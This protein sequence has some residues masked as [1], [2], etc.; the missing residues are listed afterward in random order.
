MCE[1]LISFLNASSGF[2]RVIGLFLALFFVPSF[3]FC[4][5]RSLLRPAIL[6]QD[7][8]LDQSVPGTERS[9]P[10]R[11]SRTLIRPGFSPDPPS[12][13]STRPS[14]HRQ[15]A[16]S[17]PFNF[18]ALAR[19]SAKPGRVFPVSCVPPFLL[20]QQGKFSFSNPSCLS[21]GVPPSRHCCPLTPVR[22]SPQI[23]Y[24]RSVY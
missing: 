10:I 7:R 14:S 8:P 11:S 1:F 21:G 2:G 4:F 15:E 18:P 12:E 20:D 16:I 22:P 19:V 9:V 24:G 17:V 5:Q 6:F 23:L 13:I 3:S